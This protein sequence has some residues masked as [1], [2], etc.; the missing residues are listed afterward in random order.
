MSKLFEEHGYVEE[1]ADHLYYWRASTLWRLAESLPVQ[2]I[3]LDTFD[4]TN[5]N[6]QFGPP[7]QPMLWRDVGDEA[8]RILNADLKYPIILSAEGNVMDGM[9]RILKCY[10]FGA[11]TVPAVR[12]VQT[13]PPDRTIARSDLPQ[14]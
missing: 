10:V 12:F 14:E 5:A 9:H 7:R 2:A 8:R 4:W 13:P 11:P 6:F 1:D 3:P